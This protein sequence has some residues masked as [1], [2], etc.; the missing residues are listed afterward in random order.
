[1][2]FCPK[3]LVKNDINTFLSKLECNIPW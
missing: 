1:L 3:S 2:C